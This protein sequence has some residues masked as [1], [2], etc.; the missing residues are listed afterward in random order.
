M[1]SVKKMSGSR[2]IGEL[3][4]GGEILSAHT[5]GGEISVTEK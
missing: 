4:G 2:L 1:T 3:N 5:S